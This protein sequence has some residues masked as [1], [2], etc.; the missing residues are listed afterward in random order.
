MNK[1][2]P[3]TVCTAGASQ[4]SGG[5]VLPVNFGGIPPIGT[6]GDSVMPGAAIHRAVLF[7]SPQM[8]RECAWCI[9]EQGLPPT[10]G[11]SHGICDRHSAALLAELDQ[12]KSAR[13]AERLEVA[14]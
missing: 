5:Q 8:L 14:P 9:Q 6:A 10:P 11:A 7:S 13:A 12:M 4:G 2:F 3:M 1:N